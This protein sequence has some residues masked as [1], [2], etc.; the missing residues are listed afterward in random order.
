MVNTVFV[1]P[2]I[3][4]RMRKMP[5]SDFVMLQD[6]RDIYLIGIVFT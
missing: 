3:F 2:V 6:F 5:W 4:I 1:Y